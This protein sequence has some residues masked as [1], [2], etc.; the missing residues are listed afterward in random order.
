[1]DDSELIRLQRRVASLQ[2]IEA[3]KWRDC[4]VAQAALWQI[5]RNEPISDEGTPADHEAAR[6]LEAWVA[7]RRDVEDAVR[8]MITYATRKASGMTGFWE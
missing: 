4:E 3:E 2:A 6:T 1:M 5:E 7:G 8:E